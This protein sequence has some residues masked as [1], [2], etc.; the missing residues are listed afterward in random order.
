M[1]RLPAALLVVSLALALSGCAALGLTGGSVVGSAVG[2]GT[3]AAMKAGTE[4]RLNGVAY[5]TFTAPLAEVHEAIRSTLAAMSVPLERDRLTDDGRWEL[6]GR[7][8]NRKFQIRLEPLTSTLTSMRL[9]VKRGWFGHDQATASEIIAQ[10]EHALD[11]A[12]ALPP[13]AGPGLLQ[14]VPPRALGGQLPPTLLGL[15]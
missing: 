2:A 11:T 6:R 12:F 15:A 13:G 10:T 4:Y 1:T 5:R 7:A 3:G 14:A 8:A 9:A